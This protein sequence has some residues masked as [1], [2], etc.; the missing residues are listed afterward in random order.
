MLLRLFNDCLQRFEPSKRR[1]EG[2]DD[3]VK[4]VLSVVPAITNN[5][6]IIEQNK[7]CCGV[8]S[9]S[10]N[11]ALRERKGIV[12]KG[13]SG[14]STVL[15]ER[16]SYGGSGAFGLVDSDAAVFHEGNAA[17]KVLTNKETRSHVAGRSLLGEISCSARCVVHITCCYRAIS[18]CS[19]GLLTP[20]SDIFVSRS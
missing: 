18:I 12:F 5:V 17:A 6:W 11:Y 19:V 20:R 3:E 1:R 13:D 15:I 2:W 4:V 10:R 16:G 8:S 9:S 7:R 14:K